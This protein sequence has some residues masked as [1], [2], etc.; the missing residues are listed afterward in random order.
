MSISKKD[1]TGIDRRDLIKGAAAT[2]TLA[3]AGPWFISSEVLASSGELNVL[4]WA[5]YLPPEWRAAFT[6]NTGIKLNF[7]GVGSNE[8]IISNMQKGGFDICSP[9]NNRSPLWADLGLLQPWDYSKITTLKNA[10][11]FML[12][13][14][15]SEWN[16]GGKGP[17]WVPQIWGTEGIGWRTDKWAPEGLPSFGDV[18][19]D[20]NKGQGLIRPHSG[21]MGAGLYMETIGELAPG[22]MWKAYNSK[23][24][25]KQ[26]WDKVTKWCIARKGN[27][28]QFFYDAKDQKKAF[29][30]DGIIIGQT[31]DGPLLA[32]KTEGKPVTYQAP[33]EGALAWVDGLSL[34]K[35]AKNLE[36]A[37]EFAKFCFEP[38]P[39][40][41]AIDTH[42]YNSAVKGADKFAG[43]Q[44]RNNFT[45]AYPGDALSKLNPWPAE[46]KWY[47]DLRTEYAN[48]LVKA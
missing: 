45:E 31:W 47:I 40:G 15:E 12:K 19:S 48:K 13:L 21:M 22:S 20:K 27:I 18:W 39:A 36:Q 32:L 3:A 34:A 24:D 28:K 23:D 17:H 38:A 41:K 5:D 44:Y 9:T 16:F 29:M 6:K 26:V 10:N 8:E 1:S 37:Y 11:D 7:T 14:G 43:A 30:D 46:P 35:D 33:K 4:M 2:L 42:G 25:M